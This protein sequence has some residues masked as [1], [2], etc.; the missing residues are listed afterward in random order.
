LTQIV[1]ET[2]Y[3]AALWAKTFIKRTFLNVSD[4]SAIIS[5]NFSDSRTNISR[6]NVILCKHSRLFKKHPFQELVQIFDAKISCKKTVILC[7]HSLLLKKL[8][9]DFQ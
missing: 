4:I 1:S 8:P 7:K 3:Y 6:K 5:R 9:E 2:M